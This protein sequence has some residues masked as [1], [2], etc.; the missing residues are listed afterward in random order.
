MAGGPSSARAAGA[1]FCA[2]ARRQLCV[3]PR[4]VPAGRRRKKSRL[5]VDFSRNPQ[6][7]KAAP[8]LDHYKKPF[9]GSKFYFTTIAAEIPPDIRRDVESRAAVD[10][11]TEGI[12]AFCGMDGRWKSEQRCW[13]LVTAE[14]VVVSS[15]AG[16]IEQNF[17]SQLSGVETSGVG[18]VVLLSP[19]NSTGLFS[20]FVNPDPDLIERMFRII[21][22][23]WLEVRRRASS[24]SQGGLSSSS[25]I[26][27]LERL[28]KLREAGHLTDEEFVAQKQRILGSQPDSSRPEKSATAEPVDS[29]DEA[30]DFATRRLCSDGSCV[31]VLDAHGRCR[32][33]HHQ[34]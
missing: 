13:V 20:L 16:G 32:A 21:Q 30:T 5:P 29:C 17:F 11:G 27:A 7:T 31:G 19:G 22:T 14:R 28:A 4:A 8:L 26:D 12:V 33:C 24:P 9:L 34:H 10:F 18:G 23:R 1:P 25:A 6:R 15:L 2:R 3:T